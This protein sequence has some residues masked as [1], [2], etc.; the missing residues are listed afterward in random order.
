VLAAEHLSNL[1]GIDDFRKLFEPGREIGKHVL[2]LTRPLDEHAEVIRALRQRR[3]QRELFLEAPAALE[4]LLCFSLIAPEIR[5]GGTGFYVGKFV[6]R[7]GGLKDN[8]A[9]RTRA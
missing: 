3:D 6:G 8:S 4:N 1:A 7:A 5:S 2:T 9:D